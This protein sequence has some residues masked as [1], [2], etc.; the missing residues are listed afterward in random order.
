MRCHSYNWKLIVSATFK[1]SFNLAEISIETLLFP[2]IPNS[3]CHHIIT[4][5]KSRTLGLSAAFNSKNALPFLVSARFEIPKNAI[6]RSVVE[7]RIVTFQI[8]L[9]FYII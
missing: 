8:V 1:D 3:T 7:Q 9:A 6:F 5:T 2:S 4:Y